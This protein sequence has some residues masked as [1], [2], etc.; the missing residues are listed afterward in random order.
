MGAA[1]LRDISGCMLGFFSE[2]AQMSLTR[3]CGANRLKFGRTAPVCAELVVLSQRL[4]AICLLV[5]Y[6][7]PAGLGPHWHHHDHACPQHC[8]MDEHVHEASSLDD[9]SPESD[10]HCHVAAEPAEKATVDP[11]GTEHTAE[12]GVLEL[13]SHVDSCLI[14]DFYSLAQ[15]PAPTEP[16]LSNSVL[17]ASLTEADLPPSTRSALTT[18]ARGPP[19]LAW[20]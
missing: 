13:G 19:C 10:C 17:V 18:R 9:T 7:I 1:A 4:I 12:P 2:A 15:S 20:L 5:L 8:H 14:C 11:S 16:S 6:G 3:M